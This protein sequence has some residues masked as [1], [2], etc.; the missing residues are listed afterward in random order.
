MTT[1]SNR[2]VRDVFRGW[3]VVL[4]SMGI[5]FA[6]LYT[7]SLTGTVLDPSGAPV[8]DADVTLRMPTATFGT[9]RKPTTPAATSS[10]RYLLATIRSKWKRP[11]FDTPRNPCHCH[12]SEWERV[13]GCKAA[14]FRPTRKRS[15]PG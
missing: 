6:Q 3:V 2:S 4:C 5:A 8:H 14:A 1:S 7:G 10:D 15:G 11:D 13:R 12:R 9:P